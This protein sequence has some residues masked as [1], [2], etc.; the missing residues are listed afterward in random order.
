MTDEQLDDLIARLNEKAEACARLAEL[1]HTASNGRSVAEV[2]RLKGKA[3]GVWLALS[4]LE[5]VRRG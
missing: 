3:E 1:K 4:F 5:E 2:A